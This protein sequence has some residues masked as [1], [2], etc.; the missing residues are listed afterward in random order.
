MRAKDE[1]DL[2]ATGQIQERKQVVKPLLSSEIFWFGG[3]R[4]TVMI[5]PIVGPEEESD[6]IFRRP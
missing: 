2:E 5:S 3:L 4:E 6:L 1:S